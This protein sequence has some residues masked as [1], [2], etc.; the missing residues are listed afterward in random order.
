MS[1][2]TADYPILVV[3]PSAA[4]GGGGPG[5]ARGGSVER[6]RADVYAGASRRAL[7]PLP[8]GSQCAGGS[9]TRP[10]ESRGSVAATPT[11]S[12]NRSIRITMPPPAT[13][14]CRGGS[15]TCRT[16][17]PWRRWSVAGN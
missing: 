7:D 17:K 16:D 10:G 5:R 11:S 3:P 13:P 9:P 14:G 8:R 4:A 1:V 15:P 2:L 12:T 6:P